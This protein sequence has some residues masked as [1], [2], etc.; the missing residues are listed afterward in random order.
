MEVKV[1]PTLRS[2]N[3]ASNGDG[4]QV[5][6]GAEIGPIRSRRQ[7]VRLGSFVLWVIL[8]TLGGAVAWEVFRTEARSKLGIVDQQ[9]ASIAQPTPNT[10]DLAALIKELATLVKELRSAEQVT[11]SDVKKALELLAS[12]QA[13]AKT[14][15]DTVAALQS[16]LD[17][18]VQRPAP[19]V[20]VNKPPVAVRKPP[21]AALA[22]AVPRPPLPL[23]EPKQQLEPPPGVPTPLPR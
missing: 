7:G 2:G 10:D 6:D 16:K 11:S 14:L 19:P 18:A 22:P 3:T 23:T 4:P 1:E 17:A 5:S 12:E 13:T 8:A 20:A 21:V 15:H 9:A